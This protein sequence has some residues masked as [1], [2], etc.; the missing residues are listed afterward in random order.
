MT[1]ATLLHEVQSSS[2]KCGR[3][4]HGARPLAV[5]RFMPASFMRCRRGAAVSRLLR[6]AS[7]RC[8]HQERSRSSSSGNGA[9]ASAAAA[10]S[11]KSSHSATLMSRH[12]AGLLSLARTERCSSKK[13][14][15]SLSLGFDAFF[16]VRASSIGRLATAA[17]ARGSSSRAKDTARQRSAGQTAATSASCSAFR[18]SPSRL[19]S[20]SRC[21]APGGSARSSPTS[22]RKQPSSCRDAQLAGLLSSTET[23]VS[24]SQKRTSSRAS[25]GHLA[26]SATMCPSSRP[27]MHSTPSSSSVGMEPRA[28]SAAPE[29][30]GQQPRSK[31][32]RG[33]PAKSLT[34]AATAA[35]SRSSRPR[36]LNRW[37]APWPQRR[38]RLR[39]SLATTLHAVPSLKSMLCQSDG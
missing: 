13:E 19:S 11:A 15:Q 36:R 6:P 30:F 20:S 9:A 5:R 35:S 27:R 3:R 21:Q 37:T 28:R 18:S 14:A 12:S 1:S 24:H 10:P 31:A 8:Q 2:S 17:R 7:L 4:Q 39:M 38:I 29:T 16:S 23:S 33:P 25:R 22:R 32:R 26:Q 34:R